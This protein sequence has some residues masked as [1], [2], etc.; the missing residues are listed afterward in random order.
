MT[1]KFEVGKKYTRSADNNRVHTFIG[2]RY[3][4]Y[5]GMR[6]WENSS[7]SLWAENDGIEWREYKE[8]KVHTRYGVW[9]RLK[10]EINV[11][12]VDHVDPARDLTSNCVILKHF[13]E[14]YTEE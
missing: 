7:H 13:K 8:P 1:K 11:Y 4:K 10:G 14:E 2:Y 6:V 5:A 9:Y 12:L 3:G